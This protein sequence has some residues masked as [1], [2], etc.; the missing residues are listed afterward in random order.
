MAIM[1]FEIIFAPEALEDYHS[2]N[3]REKAT[4][5]QAI[6]THLRHEP[7][8]ESKSRIKRLRKFLQPQY[9]LRVNDHRVFYDI[10]EFSVEILGIVFKPDADAWLAQFGTLPPEEEEL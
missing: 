5:K 10:L 2:F 7:S 3:A 8:K 4:L 9:R 1:A 6:E